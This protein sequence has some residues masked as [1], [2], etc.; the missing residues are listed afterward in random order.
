MLT[1]FNCKITKLLLKSRK[2]IQQANALENT[3]KSTFFRNVHGN[4]LPVDQ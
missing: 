2:L 4:N 3:V 1:F